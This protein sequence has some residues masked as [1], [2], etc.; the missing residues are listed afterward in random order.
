MAEEDPIKIVKVRFA[1][2]EITASQYEEMLSYLLEDVS[3]VQKEPVLDTPVLS[4]DPV[5]TETLDIDSSDEPSP[6]THDEL[7]LT[8]ATQDSSVSD[9]DSDEPLGDDPISEEIFPSHYSSDI[10]DPSE[11]VENLKPAASSIPES[12][13]LTDA[14]LSAGLVD[15]NRILEEQIEE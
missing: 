2:G 8:P 10:K 9:Y 1:K 14:T 15:E 13:Y 3:S 11:P 12:Q 5:N 4:T 7:V 6:Q